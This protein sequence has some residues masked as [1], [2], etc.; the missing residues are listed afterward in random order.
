MIPADNA[1]VPF[2]VQSLLLPGSAAEFSFPRFLT[3]GQATL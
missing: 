2:M 3:F 1:F